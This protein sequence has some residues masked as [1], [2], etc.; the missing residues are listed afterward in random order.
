V[1]SPYEVLGVAPDASADDIRKAY[2]KLAKQHHPDL[3]PGNQA[4]EQRF[5]DVSAANE[6]LSDPDKRAR[7]DRGEIDETGAERPPQHYYRGFAEG[8][9]GARYQPEHAMHGEDLEDLFANFFHGAQGQAASGGSGGGH[10]R[11]RGRDHSYSLAIDFLEA[12]NGAKKRITLPD[13]A[14]LDVTIP[15]GLQDGQ[16]LRLRGKGGAGLGDGPP[17]DALVE[18]HVAAHAFFRRAGNDIHVALPVTVAEAVLGAK[19]TV[20]TVGGPVAVTVPP[21]AD[22]GKVLR[23]RGRGVPAHGSAPAGDALVTLTVVIGPDQDE[24]LADFLKGWAPAHPYDP[25]AA[26]VAP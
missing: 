19:V 9:E 12:V 25:R 21:Q 7:F 6:L 16:I 1:P 20:P 22:S 4:A 5:K 11:A 8:A 23:L 24:A 3:N 18:I 13:G 17:G 14:S 15:A 10:F 2:R 26:M